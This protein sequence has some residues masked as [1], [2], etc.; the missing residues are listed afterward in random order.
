MNTDRRHR[1]DR[2]QHQG[3]TDDDGLDADD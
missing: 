3:G 1:D 2:E